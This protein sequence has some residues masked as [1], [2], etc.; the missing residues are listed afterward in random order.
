MILEIRTYRL[1]PGTRPEF[2]RLMREESGPL[3]AAAGIRVVDAGA[4]L[5]DEGDWEEAFLIRAFGSLADRDRLEE[6]FYGGDAWR[7]PG[8]DGPSLRDRVM[9]CI[10]SYHTVVLDVP[11]SVVDGLTPPS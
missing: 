1:V 10:E 4:P 11:E 6:S 3:L 5:V 9:A 8:E 2:L 7:G